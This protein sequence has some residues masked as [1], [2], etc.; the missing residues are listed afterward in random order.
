MLGSIS[1]FFLD[2]YLFYFNYFYVLQ[3]LLVGFC[4]DGA[5]ES[6]DDDDSESVVSES[7]VSE[8]ATS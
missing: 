3:T 8:S 4:R 7:V 2:F 6:D 5:G 1:T